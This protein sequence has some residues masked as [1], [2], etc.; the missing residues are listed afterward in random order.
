MLNELRIAKLGIIAENTL[1]FA[2]GFTA[3]TGETGAG[4]TMII[5]GLGLL[6]GAKAES[7]LIRYG[8]AKA[9]VEAR[10]WITPSQAAIIEDL[11]GEVEAEELLVSRVLTPNRSSS[12]L[13]GAGV[14]IKVAA[15]FMSGLLT[16]HGQSE[17]VHLAKAS[18]QREVL[19]RYAGAKLAEVLTAYRKCYRQRQKDLAELQK[20]TEAE[21]QRLQELAATT[22]ALAEIAELRPIANEDQELA[23]E[24]KRLM[25]A[26]TLI[27]AAASANLAI[28]GA[29][30][31]SFGA[32]GLV[33]QALKD[34]T[35]LANE[36]ET[37][38]NLRKSAQEIA[39]L[40]ADLGVEL[41]KYLDNL[42]PDPVRLE[43]ISARQ[44]ELQKLTRKYGSDIAA[45]LAWEEQA[46]KRV[47][48]LQNA[49]NRIVELKESVAVAGE[50]L[51]ELA[52][53]ITALRQAAA[54]ELT[55]LV[56]IE[57]QALAMPKAQL[58]FEIRP[59]QLGPDGADEVQLCFS[60]NPG[61][62][63]QPLA[64]VA[65]G[66]ELSRVR[67]ALEVVLADAN[68]GTFIF[69]EIDAGVGGEVAL[70]IG[71]RL[72]KLAQFSQ[73]IVVTH[74]AQVAAFADTQIVVQK[75]ASAEVTNSDIRE[76][77]GLER[78]AELARMMAGM[79]TDNALAHAEE[80]LKLAKST[81]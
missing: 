74:L 46:A 25:A 30:E 41:A 68:S 9:R 61:N 65:S 63:P 17:Q 7:R 77:Q 13:G 54:T 66:G 50:K 73:V 71:R 14:P 36:D 64:K 78:V 37:A 59:V 33:Q 18:R 34:L 31:D 60:A 81:S 1:N 44:A 23:G 35:T 48:E 45:V 28:S 62:P 57:L 32:Y 19:D 52:P 51:A 39:Y 79:D 75:N 69:D 56:Q 76:V 20:L 47:L 21:T 3:I 4:K 10:W 55:Q 15:D 42:E 43:W 11:G 72:R 26:E 49:D 8:A 27:T 24:A 22:A 70:E 12:F 38:E 53:Q 80:L 5:T 40:L 29:D 2:P 67:L 58:V 16:I 6:L